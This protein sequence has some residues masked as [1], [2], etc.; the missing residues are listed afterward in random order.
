MRSKMEPKKF[1]QTPQNITQKQYEALRS[2]YL[3]NKSASEVAAHFGYTLSSFYSLI[4]DFKQFL[5]KSDQP[6]KRF[7][8]D[9]PTGP[10]LK[11]LENDTYNLIV[12]LRK[13]YLAV[14]DIKS[15]LDA[16]QFSVSE[17]YIYK[18]LKQEGFAR[19]PRRSKQTKYESGSSLPVI[20]PKTVLLESVD[21]IFNSPNVGIFSFIPFIVEYGIDKLIN[22]SL[23]PGT[24]TLPKL[25]SILSFLALKLS[26]IRRYSA[27]DLWCMD[28]GLGL[29]AGLN[30]LPKT[31]WFTLNSRKNY[32]YVSLI[33]YQTY[34]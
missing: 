17:T 27:D 7:F 26:N 5:N 9:P 18:V 23:Y 14:S 29:F 19:L 25:N 8:I 21:E 34:E 3:E 15:I 11:K 20:A 30:V 16:Q 2:F 4:R 24:K 1:F 28:R 6:V 12:L 22:G 32:T 31:A 33:I 13:K 10:K